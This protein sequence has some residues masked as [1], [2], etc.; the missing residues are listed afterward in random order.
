MANKSTSGVE[1]EGNVEVPIDGGTLLLTNVRL[2][3]DLVESP[4]RSH[5]FEAELT[6]DSVWV[7]KEVPPPARLLCYAVPI[8]N[9]NLQPDLV[10]MNI[11]TARKNDS[12]LSLVRRY[13]KTVS[14]PLTVWHKRLAHLN[15]RDIATL[16]KDPRTGIQV[17]GVKLLGLY[18][19][20][21]KAKMT[22]KPFK[23]M[24]RCTRPAAR[25]LVNLV[26][27]GSTLYDTA[28]YPTVGAATV[29]KDF[30][31][32][33]ESTTGRKIGYIHSDGGREFI[34]ESLIEFYTQNGIQMEVTLPSTPEQNGPAERSNR[35]IFERLWVEAAKT[36]TI[37]VNLS[38]PSTKQFGCQPDKKPL[39]AFEAWTGV[40]PTYG[41][42]RRWG[43]VLRPLY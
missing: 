6:K 20:C 36:V 15:D 8:I 12:L 33:V 19:T 31:K 41:W 30:T 37:I 34:N 28:D 21:K 4:N 9:Q 17:N 35:I 14:A 25:F 43:C 1:A 10:A 11:T 13:P 32:M 24:T 7:V 5:F 42:M 38:P 16:A 26:G 2:V 23:P 40:Q 27:G 3:K 22:K 29:L 18:D 39:T